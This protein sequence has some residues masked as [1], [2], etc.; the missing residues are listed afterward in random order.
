MFG[1]GPTE[2]IIILVVAGIFLFGGSR[3]TEFAR[4]LGRFSGE[5]QKGKMEIEREIAKAREDIGADTKKEMVE[6]K[7]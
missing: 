3:M 1:L 7:K 6:K 4:S 2:L 5:F